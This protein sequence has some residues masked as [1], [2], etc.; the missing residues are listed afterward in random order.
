MARSA[1]ATRLL[2]ALAL[3]LA[4]LA[5]TA[6]ALLAYRQV[7]P[8]LAGADVYP[9][10]SD[11][12]GHLFKT[13]YLLREV[14][15]GQIYPDLLPTWYMGLQMLR[16]HAPL[17]YYLMSALY[18]WLGDIVSAGNVFIFLAAWLGGLSVLP[19]RRW[20]GWRPALLAA[21]LY[22]WLPDHVRV[23]FA[24][25]NLPRV[26]AAV[27]LPLAIYFLAQLMLKPDNGD[28]PRRAMFGLIVSVALVALSHAMMGAIFAVCLT[29]A[30]VV[31][32]LS[33]R[34]TARR[35]AAA[36]GGVAAGLGL[37]AW[38]LLPSLTGGITSINTGALSDAAARFSPA[39]SLNPTLRFGN[40]ETFYLSVALFVA[41][42]VS[43][44]QWS[45]LSSL[46]RS[47]LISGLVAASVSFEGVYGLFV[48]LPL[49]QFLWPIRFASF[50]GP[51][52]LL[53]V[54]AALP[55][56]RWR[57]LAVLV[58]VLICI[59]F[60]PSAALA[61]GRAAPA[62]VIS[63][64]ERLR[65]LPGWRVAVADLSRL[66]S[67]PSYFLTE[68]AGREQVFGWA[69]QGA[70]TARAVAAL[71][72]AFER[73]FM[74]YVSDRLNA[75]G[76]DDV[77]VVP[78]TGVSPGLGQALVANGLSLD[79]SYGPLDLYHRQG[80]PRATLVEGAVLGIGAGAYDAAML[81]PRIVAGGSRQVDDYSPADLA[82]YSTLYLSGFSWNN[83]AKAERLVRDFAAAGGTVVIDLTGAPRDPLARVSKFLG[84]YAEPVVLNHPLTMS[85][86]MG[87]FAFA[88]FDAANVPWHAF[89]PQGVFS[90][91]LTFDYLGERAIGLAYQ[92]SGAGR[93]WFLGANLPY[94]AFLT[95]D[96]QAVRILETVLGAQA[97]QP[98]AR[99]ETPLAGYQA[100]V[101][102]YR[103]SYTLDRDGLLIVP[104]A[105]LPG[106]T[107]KID[108]Q[109]VAT[110]AL[111]TLVGLRAPAGEHQVE[112]LVR[113]TPIYTIGAGISLLV[114]IFMLAF[115]PPW[116]RWRAG[117]SGRSGR[118]AALAGLVLAMWLAVCPAAQAAGPIVIDGS[119]GDWSGQPNIGDPQGDS[120]DKD[121]DL[122]VLYWANNPDDATMYWM[123][124]RYPPQSNKAVTYYIRVDN[125]NDG[126]YDQT[127][128]VTYKAQ[129]NGADV[130]VSSGGR[131]A[132][133]P[134]DDTGK[135]GAQRVEIAVPFSSLGI[136]IHSTIRFK[137]ESQTD[138][139][140]DVQYSPVPTLGIP[141]LVGL[142]AIAILAVWWTVGRKQWRR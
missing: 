133:E 92:Q 122:Q 7:I 35:L 101:T 120:S 89:V 64:A 134:W 48:A 94:H 58:A 40:Q 13:L 42:L 132:G 49:H 5:V 80:A 14:Q 21:L 72:E 52:L 88:P 130:T 127:V 45:R 128:T 83:Q 54:V 125:N 55:A 116:R 114:V 15:Q 59:D 96:A 4:V 82:G 124:Q 44:A 112:L 119:F 97:G 18:L 90:T 135:Q 98:P 22:P 68:T 113:P 57:T 51:A 81:F 121:Q 78:T 23:A 86:E 108:G 142:A 29:L 65:D 71:N 47:L 32:A 67:S 16:Y 19:F 129:P 26:L 8:G 107:A 31:G 115:L 60:I 74:E 123:I 3:P 1:T 10:G 20:T 139:S 110:M 62:D 53:G 75:L 131:G 36:V 91:S 77:L 70:Q 95:R 33:S 63:A 102:G 103:F 137:V 50:A 100:D 9:W 84:V 105:H 140:A 6:S 69:Y 126:V 66:G 17:T 104:V 27:W 85:G 106:L 38:W 99:Q 79:I 117:R 34:V 141:V 138:S 111:D 46:S 76:V 43:L 87:A 37:S 12:W 39:V 11:T 30:A 28:N 24:E 41:T 136:T 118:V 109:P 56:W 93:I 25:G 73:G 2:S 61:H